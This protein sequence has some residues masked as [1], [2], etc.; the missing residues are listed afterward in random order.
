M[1]FFLAVQKNIVVRKCKATTTAK[2]ICETFIEKLIKL[3]CVIHNTYVNT[4]LFF[5]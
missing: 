3:F 2:K 1:M 5:C 4:S